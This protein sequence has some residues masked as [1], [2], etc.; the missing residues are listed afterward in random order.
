VRISLLVVLWLGIALVGCRS[1]SP[2][3]CS[4]STCTSGARQG[5]TVKVC[6]RPDGSV[7]YEFGGSSCSCRVGTGGC[8]CGQKV[9]DWCD[10]TSGA[11]GGAGGS[12]GSGGGGGGSGGGA[13]PA[14]LGS[15][16]TD[17]AP[18]HEC[19]VT[20]SGGISGTG[21]CIGTFKYSQLADQWTFLGGSTNIPGTTYGWLGPDMLFAGQPH[22]GSF[23]HTQALHSRSFIVSNDPHPTDPNWGESYETHGVEEGS[24]TLAL[25]SLG[26]PKDESGGD[27]YYPDPHG[28]VT[29][30][31][32]QENAAATAPS[33][34][35]L[36]TF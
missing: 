11:D 34:Q 18:M 26:T 20:L 7:T 2:S 3:N 22:T 19:T 36:I 30:T 14:D 15:G 1:S 21:S 16:V 23:N 35:V 32:I 17:A 25:T 28:S 13:E 8:S 12:G 29:G 24:L 27:K 9:L 5:Q 6:A 31:L 33:V 4:T 10:N